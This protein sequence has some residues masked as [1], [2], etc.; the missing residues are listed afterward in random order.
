M[1][2]YTY[3]IRT[4][5]GNLKPIKRLRF[6]GHLLA[7]CSRGEA[8]ADSGSELVEFGLIVPTLLMLLIGIVWVGRAYNVYVTIT[9]AAREGARYAVLPSSVAAG[10]AYADEL[11]TFDNHVVPVLTADSLD[12]DKVE[13]Y[14]Q[15]AT[16]LEN[17]YPK[18]CGVVVSFSYPVEMGIPFIPVNITSISIPT[19]SQMRLENQPTDG[20]CP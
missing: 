10:N 19:Q 16:W 12:P 20:N 3:W 6:P 4:P 9:R 13:G 14:S 2:A 8:G 17:T 5:E 7:P 18:Q 1:K 15:Q 11:T